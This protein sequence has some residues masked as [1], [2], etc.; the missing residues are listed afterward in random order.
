M[1]LLI[2]IF[3]LHISKLSFLMP[4]P[5]SPKSLPLYLSIETLIPQSEIGKEV[6]TTSNQCCQHEYQRGRWTILQSTT[7][8]P[9]TTKTAS[10]ELGMVVH[11]ANQAIRQENC[12]L[13]LGTVNKASQGYKVR[14]LRKPKRLP[15]I[16]NTVQTGFLTFGNS[17]FGISPTPQC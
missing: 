4:S 7:N 15:T 6:T 17:W 9:T 3:I 12:H 8:T 16:R 13:A 14:L 2:E 10:N 1:H 11:A 5:K